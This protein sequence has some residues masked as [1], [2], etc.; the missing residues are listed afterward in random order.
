MFLT[1][2]ATRELPE[3]E[4]LGRPHGDVA[5]RLS[6]PV[7]AKDSD[8]VTTEGNVFRVYSKCISLI[9]YKHVTVYNLLRF[10]KSKTSS[11]L[12]MNNGKREKQK[13]LNEITGSLEQEI[14]HVFWIK[15]KWI[16]LMG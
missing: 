10:N 7:A 4:I 5:S 2:C 8:F 3:W 12:C 6:N 14:N 9:Q 11:N 16:R 1:H 15:V 13:Q